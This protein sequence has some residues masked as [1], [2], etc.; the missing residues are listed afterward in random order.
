VGAGG[1]K[2]RRALTRISSIAAW[3]FSIA[4]LVLA[5]REHLAHGGPSRA[6]TVIS[7]SGM[8]PERAEAGLLLLRHA[9]KLLPPYSRVA[10]VKPTGRW[11]DAGMLAVAHGQLPLQHAVPAATLEHGE[12]PDFVVTIDAPLDDPRYERMYE[13]NVGGIWKR[14]R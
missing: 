9:A 13:S 14:V 2:A 1:A 11:D 7:H 10:L 8:A 12:P 4:F 3:V 6:R 5:A